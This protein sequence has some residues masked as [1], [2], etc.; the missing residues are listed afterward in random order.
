M[1]LYCIGSVSGEQ[2]NYVRFRD[3][4]LLLRPIIGELIISRQIRYNDIDD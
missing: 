3:S 2:D 1:M 4:H